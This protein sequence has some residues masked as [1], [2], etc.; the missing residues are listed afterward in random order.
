MKEKDKSVNISHIRN[1][2]YQP[3]Q[4]QRGYQPKKEINEG[5]RPTKSISTQPPNQGSN[6]QP[7]KKDK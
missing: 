1:N 7:A 3:C 2:G 5:Y 6:V 4:K